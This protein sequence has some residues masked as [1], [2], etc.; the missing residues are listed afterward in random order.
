MNE[1]CSPPWHQ[2]MLCA[3]QLLEWLPTDTKESY[4]RKVN[5]PEYREYF[6]KMGWLE[7]SAITYKINQEGFRCEEFTDDDQLLVTLG[8]SFTVGIGL[9][10]NSIW[11]NLLGNKLQLKVANLA[12]AGNSSDTCFRL[13]QYWI[14][15]LKPKAVA[16]MTPPSPRIELLCD[17]ALN[18]SF[19]QAEIFAPYQLPKLK[20][21]PNNF[22]AHWFMIDENQKINQ[23]KNCLAIEQLCV[24][25]NI[26][27][28]MQR[29]DNQSWGK[30][31]FSRDF[32]HSGPGAHEKIA[33]EMHNDLIKITS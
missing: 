12:W 15:K 26:P 8:C 17:T 3:G 2:G 20:D 11:P 24:R 30:Y 25:N 22:L 7:P 1:H 4:D 31:E 32:L 18:K 33:E 6:S 23:I 19:N 13:A 28:V 29:V 14:P 5:D 21:V 27:F 16:M 10:Y 9:P